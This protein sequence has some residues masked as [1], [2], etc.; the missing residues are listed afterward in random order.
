M[1]FFKYGVLIKSRRVRTVSQW[2]IAL[3]NHPVSENE[4][5]DVEESLFN[6][7][8]TLGATVKVGF[9]ES[10]HP[11]TV[12][13]N[14]DS[15]WIRDVKV[16]H[17]TV[18]IFAV[19]HLNRECTEDAHRGLGPRDDQ[20]YYLIEN[21]NTDFSKVAIRKETV[22]KEISERST[23]QRSEEPLVYRIGIV[24]DPFALENG[25]LVKWRHYQD[26][27][28]VPIFEHYWRE[29]TLPY[30][31]ESMVYG[32]LE[33]IVL[34]RNADGALLWSPR[35]GCAVLSS[36]TTGN[37]PELGSVHNFL[38]K[39]C[40][41]DPTFG[42]PCYYELLPRLLCHIW[43]EIRV[44]TDNKYAC[45][46][47]DAY[48]ECGRL[49][50]KDGTVLCM[51]VPYIGKV[52]KGL[53]NYLDVLTVGVSYAFRLEFQ[54]TDDT[55]EPVIVDI[56]L[57]SDVVV[58]CRIVYA[59]PKLKTY[60]AVLEPNSPNFNNC[61]TAIDFIAIPFRV[62]YGPMKIH[63]D[64]GQLLL[65]CFGVS[66]RAPTKRQDLVTALTIKRYDKSPA[67]SD[68]RV[69]QGRTWFRTMA[70]LHTSA[71]DGPLELMC[72]RLSQKITDFSRV[73]AQM[74]SRRSIAVQAQFALTPTHQPIFL[75]RHAALTIP[76]LPKLTVEMLGRLPPLREV[77][78][79][80]FPD[81]QPAE[82]V[83]S[84][85]R[86]T[87]ERLND[88]NSILESTMDENP[89]RP[90]TWQIRSARRSPEQKIESE[91]YDE[92]AT[93]LDE[94]EY[95]RRYGDSVP[96][97]F[98]NMSIGGSSTSGETGSIGGEII[99]ESWLASSSSSAISSSPFHATSAIDVGRVGSTSSGSTIQ[100]R[101][102][103]FGYNIHRGTLTNQRTS[104]RGFG[105]VGKQKPVKYGIRKLFTHNKTAPDILFEICYKHLE[106]RT[107]LVESQYDAILSW[108]RRPNAKVTST[109]RRTIAMFGVEKVDLTLCF[110]QGRVPFKYLVRFSTRDDMPV[111]DKSMVVAFDGNFPPLPKDF[112]LGRRYRAIQFS[113]YSD[114]M[115]RI[116]AHAK[117]V[118]N[119]GLQTLE[120][121][122]DGFHQVVQDRNGR[123]WMRFRT[124]AY[125]PATPFVENDAFE[126]WDG[127]DD[128]GLVIVE[129]TP[130]LLKWLEPLNPTKFKM[131]AYHFIAEPIAGGPIEVCN[132]FPG[133]GYDPDAIVVWRM[134]VEFSDEVPVPELYNRV[135]NMLPSKVELGRQKVD[136]DQMIRDYGLFKTMDI[137]AKLAQ[138]K[139]DHLRELG[140]PRVKWH[141]GPE[142]KPEIERRK[143]GIVERR[144]T[145][146]AT[147]RMLLAEL[148]SLQDEGL[149]LHVKTKD[150]EDM[151]TKFD[152][153][154]DDNHEYCFKRRNRALTVG[155]NFMTDI[156]LKGQA[157]LALNEK[158]HYADLLKAMSNC[159][160]LNSTYIKKSDEVKKMLRFMYKNKLHFYL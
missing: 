63:I 20:E 25:T 97:S 80:L 137:N 27:L 98:H 145:L 22:D 109:K 143:V 6:F 121:S 113:F 46:Y 120:G 123:E 150:V 158:K 19:V 24:W 36:A 147:M 45:V 129:K 111:A 62:L 86:Q 116:G 13:K 118:G 154:D 2:R 159:I 87:R 99:T 11:M 132:L 60:F 112:E 160:G 35:M 4:C 54:K 136:P 139:I 127:V 73:S 115:V 76:L 95:A 56:Q 141:E 3:V 88:G 155:C 81:S 72:T 21:E 104:P 85:S 79:S 69:F 77:F 92:V 84:V 31:S 101:P 17:S 122:L 12:N 59:S 153:M 37:I 96:D 7:R 68:F 90:P 78:A 131:D 124:K 50:E 119:V 71:P 140:D 134:V 65:H 26:F 40:I 55:F 148:R 108:L 89:T 117:D 114:R 130:Q 61:K 125:R 126:L 102:S 30:V 152:G 135:L 49:F 39:R 38:V 133:R 64:A 144:E 33:G 43:R 82:P 70:H 149:F 107:M 110:E 94:S 48:C 41:A 8:P 23:M 57:D 18:V 42:V 75:L 47:I 103:L 151:I 146:L 29:P 142:L 93:I 91:G 15:E 138:Q 53:E 156:L 9:D 10:G 83:R 5:V 67:D 128:S 14:S 16:V 28:P 74:H 32:V 157:Y 44:V 105:G 51:N 1:I 58:D 34:Q 52:T 66:V 106:F 100:R